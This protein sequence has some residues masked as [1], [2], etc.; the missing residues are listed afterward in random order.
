[1]IKNADYIKRW[2]AYHYVRVKMVETLDDVALLMKFGET[3]V[4]RTF[5]GV[6][7]EKIFN[8]LTNLKKCLSA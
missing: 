5:D 1:M 2:V 6:S 8:E 7:H 3:C 4:R